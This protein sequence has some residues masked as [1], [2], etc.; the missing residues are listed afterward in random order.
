MYSA[1]VSEN[2]VIGALMNDVNLIMEAQELRD[3]YFTV[4]AN[5]LIYL[6]I[7]K[8]FKAGS[9]D[10][11]I[12]DI[13]AFLETTKKY[14]N[15]ID[16]EGGIEYLD[17]IQAMGEG[18]TYKNLKAHIDQVCECAFKNDLVSLMDDSKS[19][20]DTSKDSIKKLY[21]FVEGKLLLLKGKYTTGHK[22]ERLGDRM[23]KINE[24]IEKSTNERFSGYPT[25]FQ[26]VDEYFSYEPGELV[27]LSAPAKFGK[28]QYVVDLV[29][30]LC[31]Q[32]NV[33]IAVIDSELSDVFFVKRLIAK[34]MGVSFNFIK[35]GK[36][37]EH[38]WAREAYDKANTL[39]K[40]SSLYH[41]YVTG[42]K[43][44]EIQSELKRIAIQ[45]NIKIVVWDY[46]KI[47]DV[48]ENKKENVEL[49]NLTNFLKNKIAGELNLAVVAMA[50]TSDYSKSEGSLRIWG[51]NQIKQFASTI[52]Y[53]VKKTKEQI[54]DDFGME[55]GGNMYMFVKENRNGASMT[56]ESKGI[57]F[58]FDKS[59]ALFKLAPFQ[60]PEV[61]EMP[62]SN[63]EEVV[64]GKKLE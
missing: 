41:Q 49:A 7:K 56:D 14:K 22:M 40:E 3:S 58:I 37:K 36:Y 42:W 20:I 11:D 60:H 4:Q 31:I 28:S 25:G 15:M 21:E 55:Q 39:I 10:I 13:Y 61:L 30:K 48:G 43:T 50:Q 2:V 59:K 54:E 47:E 19:Y 62:K 57:N 18:Y 33:P 32:H 45:D 9:T 6:T 64:N 12:V 53:L 44:E 52:V 34:I 63:D 51:S 35:Y 26:L 17:T 5:R 23:D 38:D 16:A 8:L 27:V 46:L 29:Y 1:V 24:T